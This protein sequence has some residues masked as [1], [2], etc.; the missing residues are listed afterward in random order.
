LK[1]VA[2]GKVYAEVSAESKANPTDQKLQLQKQ[3][4]FQGETLRGMLL[5][6]GYAFGTIG[7]IARVAA[8]IAFVSSAVMF[9]LAVLLARQINKR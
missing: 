8:I 9:V 2:G 4:L 1:K 7:N 6:N 5:G 3:T